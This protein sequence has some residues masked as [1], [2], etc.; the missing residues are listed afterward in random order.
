MPDAGRARIFTGGPDAGSIQAAHIAQSQPSVPV[1]RCEFEKLVMP[2]HRGKYAVAI[3]SE[4][5]QY[6][7]LD[8]ALP[9]MAEILQPG[10][11]W[12]ASD[13]LRFRIR[14]TN[15]PCVGRIPRSR[16]VGRLED[17]AGEGYHRQYS[18]HAAVCAHVGVAIWN[19]VFRV[20]G[21][22]GCG[23]NSRGFIISARMC[24]M[25]CAGWRRTICD[26]LIRSGSRRTANTWCWRWKETLSK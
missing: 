20:G 19:S 17:H 15:V 18:A 12:V 1:V 5:L 11:K 16:D 6:L 26:A 4:S 25:S 23:E 9:V 13:F 14:E 3:T 21:A 8:I 22:C 10:G 24:W 2:D 7:K